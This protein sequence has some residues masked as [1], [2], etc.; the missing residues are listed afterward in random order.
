MVLAQESPY[1]GNEVR[2]IDVMSAL[3]VKAGGN[4]Q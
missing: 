4:H 2:S 1:W 3:R